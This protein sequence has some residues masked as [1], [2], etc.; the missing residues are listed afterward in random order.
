ML[1]FMGLQ[2]LGLILVFMFPAIALWLPNLL[3]AR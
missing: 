1:D 3:F 2:V